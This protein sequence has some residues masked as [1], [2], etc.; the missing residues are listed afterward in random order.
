MGAIDHLEEVILVPRNGLGNR[1]QAWSS[2][3]I[4]AAQVDVPLKIMW[5]PED[6]ASASASD[7]F[8][9]S[10][11]EQT[12]VTRDYVDGVLGTAH[13]SLPRYLWE[14]PHRGTIV[15]AGHDRG[16]QVFMAQLVAMLTRLEAPRRL[17]IIAGGLFHTPDDVNFMRQ[18]QIFYKNLRWS[19]PIESVA[20]EQLESHARYCAL[21]IRQTDRSLEAPSRRSIEQGLR[22]LMATT[23]L[24]DVFVAA[25]T[26]QGRNF[27]VAAAARMGFTPWT[28]HITEFDRRAVAGT[29]GAALDWVLLSRAQ[30]ILY[31]R[32]STF[33]AEAALASGHL[34]VSVP[35]EA[36]PALRSIR[37]TK[38][39][40]HSAVTYP[41]R[42]WG[43][44]NS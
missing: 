6:A 29:V 25:D 27:W 32:A 7:L 15:L 14:D 31:P 44:S 21:H 17:V 34:P 13:E 20:R 23:G 2:A 8:D 37:K 24:H 22:T 35:L 39:L 33:S 3:A 30:G 26:A 36:S 19:D 11:T 12:F 9:L 4:L 1:L 18:R 28:A 41:V 40:A 16:E 5:E 43:S 42:H 10:R 38:R